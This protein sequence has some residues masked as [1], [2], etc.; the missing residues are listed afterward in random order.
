PEIVDALGDKAPVLAAGGIGTGRQVA[1]ALALG[2]QGV[3]MGSA[4]LTSA[5]Y[6]LGHRKPSG[7]SPIQERLVRVCVAVREDVRG[8]H[9]P[10]GVSTIREALRRANSGDT[11]RRRIYTGKP[12]RLL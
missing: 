7:V 1:A 10:S 8:H 9:K 6:D 5:E 4:F 3:W 12:A 2:A 11:V